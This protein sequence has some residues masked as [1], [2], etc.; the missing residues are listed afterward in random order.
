LDPH[1]ILAGHDDLIP[2]P[3]KR[4]TEIKNHHQN[5]LYEISN[6]VYNNPLPPYQISMRHWED[7]D[8]INKIFATGE[9]LVHLNYLEDRGVVQKEE[10]DG[11]IY[12]SSKKPWDKIEY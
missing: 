2:D 7:L 3:H 8:G 11:V 6:I 9:C 4:I 1:I 5:R 10:K 12:Y